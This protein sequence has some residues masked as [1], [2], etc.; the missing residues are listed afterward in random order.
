MLVVGKISAINFIN[1]SP[2]ILAIR[3]ENSIMYVLF[4]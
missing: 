1:Y 4:D 2:I 3:L